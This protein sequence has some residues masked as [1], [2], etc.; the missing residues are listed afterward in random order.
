MGTF[1][2]HLL[3]W[4]VGVWVFFLFSIASCLLLVGKRL[5]VLLA[6]L[7]FSTILHPHSLLK[8]APTLE[9][10][11]FS[12]SIFHLSQI[13]QHSSYNSRRQLSLL[14]SCLLCCSHSSSFLF[15]LLLSKLGSLYSNISHV[16]KN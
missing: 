3:W 13:P 7:A 5:S 14:T 10:L 15:A 2:L 16:I 1:K 4:F 8:M 9:I 11:Y 6:C 12:A